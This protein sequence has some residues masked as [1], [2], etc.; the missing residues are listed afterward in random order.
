M[1]QLCYWCTASRIDANTRYLVDNAS[2]II[3]VFA[4]AVFLVDF[5]IQTSHPNH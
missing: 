4:I 2:Y 1:G 5:T 3:F